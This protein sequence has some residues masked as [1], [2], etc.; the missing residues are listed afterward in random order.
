MSV[1]YNTSYI[2][3]EK[4]Q[5]HPGDLFI[6]KENEVYVLLWDVIERTYI[7]V[8][9]NGRNIWSRNTD[10]LSCCKGLIKLPKDSKVI[11]TQE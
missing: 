2:E 3:L 4:S 8:N 9:L 11:I 6:S 5:I 1:E 7:T 10:I